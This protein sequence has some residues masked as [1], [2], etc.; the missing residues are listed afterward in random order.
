MNIVHLNVQQLDC[1]I[2]K[3]TSKL[4][5]AIRALRG[6]LH[7]KEAKV[8]IILLTRP[9]VGRSWP[10]GVLLGCSS[11]EPNETIVGTL[12]VKGPVS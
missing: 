8:R 11:L 6:L 7:P 12:S 9:P 5:L 1:C 3:N 4:V 10:V 2:L